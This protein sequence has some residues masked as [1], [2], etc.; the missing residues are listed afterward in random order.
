MN[1]PTQI[2]VIVPVWNEQGSLDQLIGRIH[3]TFVSHDVTYE[4]IFIDDHS[5]DESMNIITKAAETYPIRAFAKVGTRGKAQSIYEGLEHVQ[6]PTVAMID[7]DL[8]YPPEAL[9][10]MFEMIRTNSTDV[11]VANRTNQGTS[12][13]R[14]LVH[15]ACRIGLGKVL[16]G[17]D[18]DIQSG[19]K[20]FRQDVA[21]HIAQ[22]ESG[23]AFDLEFLI[24]ARRAGYRIGHYDITFAKRQADASKINMIEGAW[25]IGTSALKLKFDELR[26]KQNAHA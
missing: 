7:A 3:A 20:V 17:F 14:Q 10:P 24:T 13:V 15:K 21:P 5:T 4:I 12:T 1:I 11:V 25:Q 16:H 9:Y 2:S 23:W 22:P 18:C 6:Y 26:H 19:M 8:Q